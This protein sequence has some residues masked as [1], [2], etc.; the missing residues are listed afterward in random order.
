MAV[1][2]TSLSE[3]SNSVKA[4][5][6]K[7]WNRTNHT[8]EIS[9]RLCLFQLK[10]PPTT[11][12][13]HI[14]LSGREGAGS[15]SQRW[16][17]GNNTE[18]ALCMC[19]AT[20]RVMSVRSHISALEVKKEKERG[21]KREEKDSWKWKERNF[22]HSCRKLCDLWTATVFLLVDLEFTQEL[23]SLCKLPWRPIPFYHHL[24][25]RWPWTR[26]WALVSSPARGN[27]DTSLLGLCWEL[28]ETIH[29][30]L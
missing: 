5:L 7:N 4:R 8:L 11:T 15:R 26:F 21:R 17:K 16:R 14:Y 27:N 10:H 6:W 29:R 20:C 1:L 18:A 12:T 9:D 28:N 19:R 2:V 30:N 3:L 25:A 24:L 13:L 22:Q 23:G